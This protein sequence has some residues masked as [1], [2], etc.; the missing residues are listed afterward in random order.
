VP[1]SHSTLTPKQ[2]KYLSLLQHAESEQLSV[3]HVA[4]QNDIDPSLLYAARKTLRQKGVLPQ[5]TS[6]DKFQSAPISTTVS[7]NIELKAQLANG[8]PVWLSVPCHQLSA[9]LKALSV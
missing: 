7:S 1:T 6:S 2:Q 4:K 3:I 5:A 9:T 8:Q